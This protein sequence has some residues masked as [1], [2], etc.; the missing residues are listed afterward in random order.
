M[1]HFKTKIISSPKCVSNKIR[2]TNLLASITRTNRTYKINTQCNKIIVNRR[3]NFKEKL[4]WPYKEYRDNRL[5]TRPL[6]R[7]RVNDFGPFCQRTLT[8][9]SPVV[10]YKVYKF[11]KQQFPP[12]LAINR[13]VGQNSNIASVQLVIKKWVLVLNWY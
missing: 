6:V 4:F 9:V 8:K 10:K 2:P 11:Y 1:K 7:T 3:N 13:Y 5:T 12:V